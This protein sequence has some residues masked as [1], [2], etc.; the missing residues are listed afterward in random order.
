MR[1]VWPRRQSG[2]VLA[3][4]YSSAFTST[5]TMGP[6]REAAQR[7]ALLHAR[8]QKTINKAAFEECVKIMKALGDHGRALIPGLVA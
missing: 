6:K 7:I 8:A 4:R 2:P 3:L 5:R 1:S